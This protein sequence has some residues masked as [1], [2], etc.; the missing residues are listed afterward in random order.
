MKICFKLGMRLITKYFRATKYNQISLIIN[1]VGFSIYRPSIL[2]GWQRGCGTAQFGQTRTI[3][4]NPR[5]LKKSLTIRKFLLEILIKTGV[6]VEYQDFQNMLDY[7]LTI[8]LQKQLFHCVIQTTRPSKTYMT[9]L[10]VCQDLWGDLLECFRLA[11]S[12]ALKDDL[13]ELKSVTL[14]LLF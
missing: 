2:T 1:A 10:K 12:I 7:F 3:T 6:S 8:Y 13:S 9:H 14:L 4:H 11:L 5:K